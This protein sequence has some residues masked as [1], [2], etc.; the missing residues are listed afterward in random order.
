MVTTISLLTNLR[1]IM[2][3]NKLVYVTRVKTIQS[4]AGQSFYMATSHSETLVPLRSLQFNFKAEKR[5]GY[6]ELYYVWRMR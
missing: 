2:G 3:F 1:V 4:P 6:F 5:K